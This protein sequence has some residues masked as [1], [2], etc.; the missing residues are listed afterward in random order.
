MR[1]PAA[2]LI[3]AAGCS[4]PRAGTPRDDEV[5]DAAAAPD[6]LGPRLDAPSG[7]WLDGYGKRKAVSIHFDGDEPVTEH[8]VAVRVPSDP[9]LAAGV[10]PEAIAF[11]AADGASVLAAEVVEFDAAAGALEAWVRV[12]MLSPGVPTTIYLYYAGPP[13]ADTAGAVW[14]DYRG[15]WHLSAAGDGGDDSTSGQ[16]DLDPS[17]GTPAVAPGV[18]GS[19]RAYDGDDALCIDDAETGG[20]LD[21]GG[22]SF[23][24]S[25]WVWTDNALGDD[26]SS[27]FYK[28]GASQSHRGYGL[29]LGL[30]DWSAKI[31]DG[32]DSDFDSVDFGTQATLRQA[33]HQLVTVV[34]RGAGELRAYLDGAEIAV[35]PLTMG[36]L[37]TSRDLCVGRDDLSPWHGL[38][39]EVRVQAGVRSDAAIAAEFANL[40]DAAFVTVGPA[41]AAP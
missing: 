24:Y 3:V 38:I 28:G 4:F 12:P 13:A 41:E 9:D 5:A 15:V 17:G 32:A 19:A 26:Y 31:H 29:L 22:G 7:P 36:S 27:P 16:L 1:T 34:D 39:D 25:V 11:T 40:T 2:L 21:F 10:A 20:L 18:A 6:G 30:G 23:T 33:W 8:P 35:A 37:D 14:S